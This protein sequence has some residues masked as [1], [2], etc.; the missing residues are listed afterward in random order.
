MVFDAT[1]LGLKGDVTGSFLGQGGGLHRFDLA[2]SD[3]PATWVFTD[4][5]VT[6]G[7]SETFKGTYTALSAVDEPSPAV[8][9]GI[10]VAASA[11]LRLPRRR[12]RAL[13]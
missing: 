12:T 4:V 5:H 1:T 7:V 11:W 13:S 8:L 3:T 10:G 9:L 6:G 2:L